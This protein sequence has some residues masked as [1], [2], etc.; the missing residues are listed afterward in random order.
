MTASGIRDKLNGNFWGIVITFLCTLILTLAS[1][2]YASIKDDIQELKE[3]Q[4][5]TNNMV[6]RHD[7]KIKSLEKR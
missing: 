4:H 3:Q 2:G 7:E 5:Q 1:L 6:I